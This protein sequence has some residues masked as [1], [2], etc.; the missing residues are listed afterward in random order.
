MPIDKSDGKVQ[1]MAFIPLSNEALKCLWLDGLQTFHPQYY[2]HGKYEREEPC[3]SHSTAMV[4]VNLA[5]ITNVRATGKP[6]YMIGSLI[7]LYR[8]RLKDEIAVRLP[9]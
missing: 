8:N 2:V 6:C 7:S 4:F 3:C 1:Q 9:M 5:C